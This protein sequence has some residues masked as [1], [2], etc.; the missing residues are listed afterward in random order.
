MAE[1]VAELAFA[2]EHGA[3]SLQD[4]VE[5]V[6]QVLQLGGAAP[7]TEASVDVLGAPA[8][9]LRGHL[10]HGAQRPSH[11]EPQD[12]VHPR[13]E[14][15]RQQAARRPGEL[16]QLLVGGER[17]ARDDRGDPGGRSAGRGARAGG[18]DR[19]GRCPGSPRLGGRRRPPGRSGRACCR[20]AVP[21]SSSR[22]RRSR[23]RSR[24]RRPPGPRRPGRGR[25]RRR[26]RWLRWPRRA[27]RAGGGLP[28]QR[29]AEQQ[30]GPHG[31][32]GHPD[33]HHDG[34]RPGQPA[35]Q[36]PRRGHGAVTGRP[37]GARPVSLEAVPDAVDG[38]DGAL[39]AGD[40][41]E[42]APEGR[43]T[44]WSRVLSATIAPSGHAAR[45]S[46]RRRT[47]VARF[48]MSAASSRN[49]VGVSDRR[50]PLP[51]TACCAGSSTTAAVGGGGSERPRRMRAR[52][53][54][55]SSLR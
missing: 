34:G 8:I 6:C 10:L 20:V 2:S 49:S 12:Q 51:V 4:R 38:D 13:Q 15:E 39:V 37:P 3:Q 27:P 24:V 52:R 22:Q 28:A 7:G 11:V 46:S 41:G 18:R 29:H 9:G 17:G 40:L 55:S 31:E 50:T 42:L 48:P 5:R 23:Y 36:A 44:Y 32:H 33:R 14:S 43:A 25:P 19:P 16:P 30:V 26:A 21:R 1:L 47:T 35:A 45:T 53:R 54:A